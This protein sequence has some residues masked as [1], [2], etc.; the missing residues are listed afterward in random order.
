VYH[1]LLDQ[2]G[3]LQASG[4]DH[5]KIPIHHVRTTAEAEPQRLSKP[6]FRWG[7]NSWQEEKET[8]SSNEVNK[9]V[10]LGSRNIS[11]V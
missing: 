7:Q 11:F 9:I 10:Y 6:M 3:N 2:Q 8:I 5:Q 1:N 4:V